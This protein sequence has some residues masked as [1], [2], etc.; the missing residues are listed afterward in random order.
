MIY[1]TTLILAQLPLTLVG[2]FVTWLRRNLI[3]K[4]FL[5]G[6]EPPIIILGHYRSG[7][8]FFYQLLVT[9]PA[10]TGV[11][12]YQTWWPHSFLTGATRWLARLCLP[13]SRPM[14]NV[15]VC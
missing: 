8:S 1:I 15:K 3:H 9:D 7:T 11:S 14:D 6:C 10:H 2:S 4:G 5:A 13:R 12:M